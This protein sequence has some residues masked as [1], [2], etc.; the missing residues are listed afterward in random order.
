MKLI[1]I[2][3]FQLCWMACVWGAANGYWWLGP[4]SVAAF[5][6]WELGRSIPLFREA[7]LV[8]WVIL[9]GLV[10]DSA[11][12]WFGLISYASPVPVSWLA[13]VW[14]LAMW[15][16]FALTMNQSLAWLH[17]RPVLA[18]LLGAI[19]GPLAYWAAIDVWGAAQLQA[20][21]W[22]VYGIVGAVWAVCTPLLSKIAQ[23]YAWPEF[24]Q[25]LEQKTEPE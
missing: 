19:G 24:H 7:A 5:A 12:I 2:V 8:V 14:I 15:I 9:I 13:P 23:F 6:A 11:Y 4:L 1:N 18:A 20:N 25:H 16:G 22:L 10:I 3:A 21:A 17:G